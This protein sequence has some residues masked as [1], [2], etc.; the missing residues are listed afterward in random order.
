MTI[1]PA[2]ALAALRVMEKHGLPTRTEAPQ[3]P[4]YYLSKEESEKII[5]SLK[6][7]RPSPSYGYAARR[8]K[9]KE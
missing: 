9:L 1:N 6:R 3:E 2:K 8:M 7:P 4:R 5:N